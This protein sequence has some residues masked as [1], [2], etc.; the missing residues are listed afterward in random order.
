M[1]RETFRDK[2]AKFIKML[3]T[4]KYCCKELRFK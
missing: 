1:K 3:K 2:L 4:I